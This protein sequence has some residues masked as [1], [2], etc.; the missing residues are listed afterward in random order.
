M[1]KKCL[2]IGMVVILLVS[3]VGVTSCK[4]YPDTPEDVVEESYLRLSEND[5]EECISF[6]AE[7]CYFPT[8]QEFRELVED[9]GILQTFQ[10]YDYYEVESVEI[11]GDTAM[12]IGTVYFEEESGYSPFSDNVF[13]VKE[14]GKWKICH[15]EE[16]D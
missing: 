13:L 11:E 14:D 12:V 9:Y 6:F 16:G 10:S 3:I 1:L 4:G 5:C 8:E 15:P 2:V 7:D